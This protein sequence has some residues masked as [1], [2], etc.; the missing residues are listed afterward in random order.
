MPYAA[1]PFEGLPNEREWVAL[2]NFVE[3]GRA[4]ATLR[5]GRRI[6]IVSQ[7]IGG[8]AAC[9]KEDGEI[10]V[11]IQVAHDFGDLSRDLAHAIALASEREPGSL[12]SMTDPGVGERLQDIVDPDSDFEIELLE[13]FDFW[14]PKDAEEIDMGLDTTILEANTLSHES[15]RIRPHGYITQYTSFESY[16]R[17]FV[18]ED[19]NAVLTALARLHL[20]STD[21]VGGRHLLGTFKADGI[22]VLVWEVS[23]FDD[24][25]KLAQ[26]VSNVEEALNEALALDEELTQAERSARQSLLS[27]QVVVR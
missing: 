2:R 9:V 10:Q 24:H 11:A 17:W 25:E 7:L 23:R 16:L 6:S 14:R 19:E 20:A 15:W 27:R 8:A 5:D 21:R 22:P 3:R 12:V 1:R 18:L 4:T 26:H 13:N